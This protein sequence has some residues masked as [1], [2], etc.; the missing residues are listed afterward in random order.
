MLFRSEVKRSDI[1]VGLSRKVERSRYPSDQIMKSE[2]DVKKTGSSMNH[3]H[4]PTTPPSLSRKSTEVQPSKP[5]HVQHGSSKATP[6][7]HSP[8]MTTD[9]ETGMRKFVEQPPPSEHSS[10]SHDPGSKLKKPQPRPVNASESSSSSFTTE[11]RSSASSSSAPS[12]APAPVPLRKGKGVRRAG[13]KSVRASPAQGAAKQPSGQTVPMAAAPQVR[14]HLERKESE[15]SLKS[16]DS[17]SVSSASDKSEKEESLPAEPSEVQQSPTLTKEPGTGQT[18]PL[19]LAQ[20]E[21]ILSKGKLPPETSP[22]PV[23]LGEASREK[24]CEKEQVRD[25]EQERKEREKMPL[26]LPPAPRVRSKKKL[27]Q[28]Q[29]K[30]DK[31]RKRERERDRERDRERERVREK[32]KEKQREYDGSATEPLPQD[33]VEVARKHVISSDGMAETVEQPP[34]STVQEQKVSKGATSPPRKAKLPAQNIHWESSKPGRSKTAPAQITVSPPSSPPLLPSPPPPPP[35]PPPLPP[36]PAQPDQLAKD[37]GTDSDNSPEPEP[38]SQTWGGSEL[39]HFKESPESSSPNSQPDMPLTPEKPEESG[40]VAEQV[41]GQAQSS[42]PMEAIPI[43]ALRAMRLRGLKQRKNEEQESTA[44][45]SSS[46]AQLPPRKAHGAKRQQEKLPRSSRSS[47]K[48]TIPKTSELAEP[49]AV[50]PRTAQK[51]KSAPKPPAEG[52]VFEITPSPEPLRS[53]S[54]PSLKSK[55]SLPAPTSPHEI[56]ASLL[57]NNPALKK[58]KIRSDKDRDESDEMDEGRYDEKRKLDENDVVDDGKLMWEDSDEGSPQK[59]PTM[60]LGHRYKPSTLSLDAE[61]FYPST[62]FLPRGKPPKK[63]HADAP[64]GSSHGNVPPGFTSE[65]AGIAFERKYRS[66]DH[67]PPPRPP[68]PRHHGNTLTPSPPPPPHY[69]VPSDASPLYSPYVDSPVV[70][71]SE[72]SRFSHMPTE[73]SPY[74]IPPDELAYPFY[75]AAGASGRLV[76]PG[77]DVLR[78][79]R[80]RMLRNNAMYEESLFSQQHGGGYAPQ[81]RPHERHPLAAASV[82]SSRS[83][84]NQPSSEYHLQ[85]TLAK[86]EEALIHAHRQQ[87]RY[88][89]RKYYEE[90]AKMQARR[91]YE[92]ITSINHAPHRSSRSSVYA[93]E[94]SSPNLW[95]GGYDTMPDAFPSAHGSDDAFLSESVHAHHLRQQQRQQQLLQ[96]QMGH[97]HVSH[98]RRRTYSGDNDLGGEIL[99]DLLQMPVSPG[100]SSASSGLNK[101]PGTAFSGME[102]ARAAAAVSPNSREGSLWSENAEV[103]ACTRACVCVCV[104]V[105]VCIIVCG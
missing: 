104:C 47:E 36:S 45:S 2:E 103:C 9:N 102:Q 60:V 15:S 24:E 49:T 5:A 97:V 80:G 59:H 75:S 83:L 29:R 76:S 34:L 56:A 39:A 87:R 33:T 40:N 93:N 89:L 77:V 11:R 1:T 99:P 88:L 43:S 72:P 7:D 94:A 54:D 26:P 79:P 6:T 12:S 85:V 53:E 70:D 35:P 48:T 14:D 81:R 8:A 71:A 98:T 50:E 96:E 38:F 68:P 65:E 18:I 91:S 90:Q 51:K 25:R 41:E 73:L 22:A 23:V 92:A 44:T 31:F 28:Q 58:R 46:T 27:K 16:T 62:D 21:H 32:E 42:H 74:D 30:E 13:A 61:P 95:E 4:P 55:T 105:C 100:P 84:W 86:E 37:E 66:R 101:A 82:G 19:L 17:E 78:D 69:P 63:Y 10:H 3:L 20:E 64:Y 57:S 67:H 52:I